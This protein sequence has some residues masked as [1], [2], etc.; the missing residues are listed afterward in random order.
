MGNYLIRPVNEL[1]ENISKTINFR[2]NPNTREDWT[3]YDLLKNTQGFLAGGIF[4][5]LDLFLNKNDGHRYTFANYFGIKDIDIFFESEEKFLTACET[6]QNNGF[7]KKY[8]TPNAI[9]FVSAN[10][11]IPPIEL[12]RRNFYTPIEMLKTFDFKTIKKAMFLNEKDE[13]MIAQHKEQSKDYKTKNLAFDIEDLKQYADNYTPD[14]IFE[15]ICKY[16]TIYGY[17][18]DDDNL[19][20]ILDYINSNLNLSEAIEFEDFKTVIEEPSDFVG[21]DAFSNSSNTDEVEIS[22]YSK[23]ARKLIFNELVEKRFKEDNDLVKENIE[24]LRSVFS[25][26]IRNVDS[27]KI[28]ANEPLMNEPLIE[29]GFF[30]F[31]IGINNYTDHFIINKLLKKIKVLY[32]DGFKDN[33]EKFRIIEILGN[34]FGPMRNFEIFYLLNLGLSKYGKGFMNYILDIW[35]SAGKY[36]IPPFADWVYMIE[37]DI[38]DI[39]I[40]PV[41]TFPLYLGISDTPI[42]NKD[43]YIFQTKPRKILDELFSN[44]DDFD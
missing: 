17:K 34:G 18:I 41:I 8:D 4:K 6:L 32:K 44:V 1:G 5:S 7:I 42:N 28:F 15:R 3:L 23:F 39:E 24:L 31:G 26:E 10:S 12:I 14:G 35:F 43:N 20:I 36:L 38:L 29:E 22:Y 16:K 21:K 9:G 30:T 33:E 37:N 19:K 13:L 2:N 25:L 40:S 27:N 11:L